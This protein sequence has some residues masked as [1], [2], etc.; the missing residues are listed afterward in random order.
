MSALP[1]HADNRADMQPGRL[2]ANFGLMRCSKPQG[3]RP[4]TMLVR[5]R[6]GTRA[7]SCAAG[8]RSSYAFDDAT[9][10]GSAVTPETS[11][12]AL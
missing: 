10:A 11:I 6:K 2:C 1:Q 3:D 12:R 8:S 7:T 9:R 5:C 4:W